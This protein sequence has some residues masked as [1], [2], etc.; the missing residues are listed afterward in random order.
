MTSLK[1][2]K[3]RSSKLEKRSKGPPAFAGHMSLTVSKFF[4]VLSAITRFH[5]YGLVKLFKW[6][7]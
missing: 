1:I 5:K 3:E 6:A 7:K 4:Q 2:T